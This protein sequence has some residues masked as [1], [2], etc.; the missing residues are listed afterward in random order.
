[1]DSVRGGNP[2]DTSATFS[3]SRAIVAF[4]AGKGRSH[5]GVRGFDKLTVPSLSSERP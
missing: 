4:S 3:A 1:L 2:F 5:G